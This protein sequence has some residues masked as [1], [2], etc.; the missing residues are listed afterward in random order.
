M[1]IFLVAAGIALAPALAEADWYHY[2]ADNGTVSFT[3]DLKRVPARHRDAA[4]RITARDLESY[5]RF[6]KV[7]RHAGPAGWQVESDAP[8]AE[9]YSAAPSSIHVPIGRGTLEIP[10]D[11]SEA[12]IHVRRGRYVWTDDG[13]L[14][15]HT[16]V[17]RDGRVLAIVEDAR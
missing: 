15:S 6:T 5:A 7:E 3:D 8:A 16:I 13:Y 2:E 17:E 4:Q 14:K 9:P 10:D 12:P 1:R 11:G